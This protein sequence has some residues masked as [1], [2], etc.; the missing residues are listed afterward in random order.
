MI[1]VI[2]VKYGN[3]I[4]NHEYV[5]RMYNMISKNLS[6][7]FNFYC[8]TEDAI[9][10]DE[11]INVIPLPLEYGL[12]SWWWKT[13]MFKPGLFEHDVN[14]YIDLDMIILSNIDHWMT[15]FPNRFLGLRDVGYVKNQNLNSLGS[16]VLRW[17]NNEYS[18]I[19]EYMQTN[20]PNIM[21]TYRMSGDQGYIWAKH[22][23]DITF[24]PTEWYESFKWE[25][26]KNGHKPSA[27]I[28]VFHGSR[29]PH[30]T[31]HP[32]ILEYWK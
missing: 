3:K 27:N 18:D 6:L 24:W 16:G 13:Y 2:T 5:N 15:F 9:G 8:L 14:F 28:L 29:K 11:N 7:P 21:R 25:L 4:Y 19:W 10:L 22:Y 20:A 12:H 31:R 23:M 32:I 1:N 17:K 26:E 30:N